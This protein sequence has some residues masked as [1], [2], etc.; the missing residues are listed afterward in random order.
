M[1]INIAYAY[2]D[3]ESEWNCSQWR[4]KIPSDTINQTENHRAR[5]VQVTDMINY[6][7]PVVQEFLA[8]F[9]IIVV[10]R[11]MFAE[12]I[13]RACD[14]WRAL[15]KLV[16]ADLD[17]DYPRLTVQNPAHRFW[18]LDK[19]GMRDSIGHRP[20]AGLQEGLKH[21]DLLL[22]PSR[23]ILEDWKDIIPG[24]HTPNYA[25]GPWYADIEQKE[26]GEQI[27]IGWGGSVSH[28]DSW[29]FG[30]ALDAADI[31]FERHDNVIFKICG[32]DWRLLEVLR[33]RWPADR[34]IHQ[35]GVPAE[36]W[37]KQVASFDVGL[38]PLCGPEAPQSHEYDKR[39]SWLKAVEYLM[40]GVPWV[41]SPGPVYADLAGK[42][43]VLAA[44]Y[45]GEAWADAVSDMVDNIEERKATSKE[46]MTWARNN[47]TMQ[48]NVEEYV[49]DLTHLFAVKQGAKGPKLPDVIYISDIPDETPQQAT[50]PLPVSEQVEVGA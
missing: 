48:A 18:N 37:P 35:L 13:W 45:T 6:A 17:D 30:G 40:C 25:F 3:T 36:Q 2:A 9:D 42:G 50:E 26:L 22:S 24:H 31:L 39:R 49:D 47:L 14:Y 33:E 7:H 19:K 23:L 8:A 1:N 28:F 34:W 44:D 38:A 32:H 4:C 12:E 5:L 10:Q 20:T 21:C 27:V 11:N 16:C 46:M 29:W 15:G 41:G 43:G